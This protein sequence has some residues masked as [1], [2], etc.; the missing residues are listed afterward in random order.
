MKCKT[1]KAHLLH[2]RV[3]FITH[4]VFLFIGELSAQWI[5]VAC[6]QASLTV[7]PRHYPVPKWAKL[8]RHDA[9]CMACIALGCSL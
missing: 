4:Q 8:A 9:D 7:P 3:G 5:T 6:E 2:A 1:R